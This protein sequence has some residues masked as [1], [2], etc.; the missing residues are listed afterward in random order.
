MAQATG[1]CWCWSQPG[2]GVHRGVHGCM[3]SPARRY[4]TSPSPKQKLAASFTIHV[5]YPGRAWDSIAFE[6]QLSSFRDEAQWQAS[7]S[8]SHR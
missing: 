1:H 5:S 2:R 3:P 7:F 6:R 8:L 4:E